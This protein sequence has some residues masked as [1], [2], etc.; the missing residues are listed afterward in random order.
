[1]REAKVTCE[2]KENVGEITE[3]S[4]SD[5]LCGIF[6]DK[7]NVFTCLPS[8]EGCDSFPKHLHSALSPDKASE[9]AKKQRN[10]L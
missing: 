8:S 10:T 9:G 5:E 4:F 7:I 1:M 6:G 3:Y 2:M